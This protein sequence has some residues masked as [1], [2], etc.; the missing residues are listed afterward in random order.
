MLQEIIASAKAQASERL[1]SPLIGSFAVS[2]CLWNYKF[3]VILFSDASVTKTFHLISSISFP[4]G[5]SVLVNGVLLPLLTAVAYIFLY[6]YPAKVVYGFTQRRQKEI[7]DLRRKIADETPLTLEESRTLRAEVLA[8]DTAHK[9]ELD[10]LNGEL[11]RVRDELDRARSSKVGTPTAS[12]SPG[13]SPSQ[14]KILQLLKEVGGD[15]LEKEVVPRSGPEKVQ[16]EYDLGELRRLDFTKREYDDDFRDYRHTL[17]HD[18][19][20]LV[21]K[22]DED[23]RGSA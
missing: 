21:L 22:G 8:A 23:S 6:P 4:D 9:E 14:T 2:W 16:A 5:W 11:T 18:G 13:L 12:V 10:R 7:N 1:A 15:A 3:L 19:R 20:R 17:T